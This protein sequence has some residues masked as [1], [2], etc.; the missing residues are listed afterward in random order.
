M[1]HDGLIQ[2]TAKTSGLVHAVARFRSIHLISTV[3]GT[4]AA[5]SI[6]ERAS[7]GW[8][9]LFSAVASLFL[10]LPMIGVSAIRVKENAP[11]FSGII[12]DISGGFDVFRRNRK[13]RFVTILAG[14]SLPI[15]QLA[16][17]ILSSFIRDDLGWGSEAF[18]IVDAAWP[19]G[20]MLAAVLLSL[21]I[22]G[23]S[24]KN[25]EYVF[26]IAAGVSTIGLALCTT[27]PMLVLLHGLM[28]LTVWLCRIVIDARVLQHCTAD[29]VGRT[30]MYVEVTFSV[31]AMIMCL[32]PSLVMLSSTSLYFLFWGSAMIAV[33]IG[34]WLWAELTARDGSR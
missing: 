11:G 18:A 16:N 1:A 12:A 13:V 4:I 7:P 29:M 3:A 17:A 19:M 15:G 34:L 28:G 21:G 33:S 25:M 26:A 30:K 9:L 20:G 8:G 32:S 24:R 6:I 23:L 31:A 14:V 10:T 27:L 5:G 2:G 22:A